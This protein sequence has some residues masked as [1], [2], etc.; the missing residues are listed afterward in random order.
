MTPTSNPIPEVVR[1]PIVAR[2]QVTLSALLS[3]AATVWTAHW[4]V[5]GLDYE[6]AHKRFGKIVED[7][8]E[9]ADQVAEMMRQLG[10]EPVVTAVGST[11]VADGRYGTLVS[12]A[13]S[14]LLGGLRQDIATSVDLVAQNLLIEIA[15][16]MQKH[17]MAVESGR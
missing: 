14:K 8:H 11:L 7:A 9:A 4:N 16:T 1:A 13:L 3:L 17:L 12:G 10:G 2:L 6:G 15:T 5:R